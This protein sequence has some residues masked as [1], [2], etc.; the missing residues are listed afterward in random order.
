[1]RPI[2]VGNVTLRLDAAEAGGRYFH[3]ILVLPGLFQSFLCWRGM[4]SMLAHRGWNVYVLPRPGSDPEARVGEEVARTS[5]WQRSVEQAIAAARKLDD[6]VIVL[7]ADVGAAIALAMS[8]EVDPLA[9]ALFAPSRPSALGEA[10]EKSL[11][12]IGRMRRKSEGGLV[13]PASS[14]AKGAHQP[15][16]VAPE[17]AGLLADLVAGVDFEPVRKHAPAIVFGSDHDPLVSREE[18]EAF[19]ASDYAKTSPT[20]LRGRWWPSSGWERICDEVHR[21]LILT[22]SDRVVDFPEEIIGE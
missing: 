15:S 20:V 11:G 22:L 21:F 7:G 1:M 5:G 14:L 4:T 9:L 16:D 10:H 8:A 2:S 13:H 12:V 3:P 19:A 18:S 17:P 6:E